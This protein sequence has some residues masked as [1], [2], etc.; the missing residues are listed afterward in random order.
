MIIL[1][2]FAWLSVKRKGRK[3][4]PFSRGSWGRVCRRVLYVAVYR[5]GARGAVGQKGNIVR[6]SV[7]FSTFPRGI[8]RPRRHSLLDLSLQEL[9][10]FIHRESQKRTAIDDFCTVPVRC[11][12]QRQ[13]PTASC[14]VSHIRESGGTHGRRMR[15]SCKDRPHVICSRKADG[16]GNLRPLPVRRMPV[17]FFSAS[18]ILHIVQKRRAFFVKKDAFAKKIKKEAGR[19]LDT[20][21]DALYNVV[22]MTVEGRSPSAIMIIF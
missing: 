2:P 8:Q 1:Y 19:C 9:C 18:G 13:G 17:V 20:Q 10:L 12:R 16:E 3:F 15:S 14:A 22:R 21:R 6:L 7:P 5:D 4:P 11:V